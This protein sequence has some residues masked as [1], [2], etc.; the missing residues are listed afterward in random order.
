MTLRNNLFAAMAFAAVLVGAAFNVDPAAA[1][2]GDERDDVD[3]VADENDSGNG[4]QDEDDSDDPEQDDGKA[5]LSKAG[6]MFEDAKAA[7]LKAV[8]GSVDEVDLEYEDGKLVFDV[9]VGTKTVRVDA[10]NGAVLGVLDRDATQN[11][12]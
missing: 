11:K 2:R 8:P 5:L 12:D 9:D 1:G 4:L 3:N 7:A 6:I 10:M